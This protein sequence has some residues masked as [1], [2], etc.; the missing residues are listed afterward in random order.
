MSKRVGKIFIATD[1]NKQQCDDCGK[2]AELRPYGPGG[3]CICFQ[4][5]MKDPEGLD[6]RMGQAM[7][8]EPPKGAPK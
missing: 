3:S 5:G 4:C 8:G 2:I 7:F 1:E 6:K